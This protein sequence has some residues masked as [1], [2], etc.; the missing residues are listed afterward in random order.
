MEGRMIDAKTAPYGAFLLRVS[1]GILFILHG[2]YLK[3]FVFGMTGAGK[4]FATLDLPEWFA[5]V[6]M[7][8]ETIGGLALI[9]G[10]YARWVAL[11]LGVHLLFAA[12]LGHAGNGWA[13]TNKGG[14]YE[15]PLFWAIACFT[16]TLLGDGAHALKSDGRS[17]MV[18]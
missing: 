7:L 11:F 6:V 18:G 16:L 5:W 12:Y 14:G 3:A 9:F 1:M 10:I 13:F 2:V 17:K 8:Y 15:F 4:F